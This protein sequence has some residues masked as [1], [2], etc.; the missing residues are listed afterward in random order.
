MLLKDF[1]TQVKELAIKFGYKKEDISVKVEHHNSVNVQI[2]NLKELYDDHFSNFRNAVRELGGVGNA[3]DAMIDY[4]DNY[5]CV[6]KDIS[7]YCYK[8]ISVSCHSNK[9]FY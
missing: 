1:R 2:R 7:M 8:F 5:T 4:F 9:D 3:G 6:C